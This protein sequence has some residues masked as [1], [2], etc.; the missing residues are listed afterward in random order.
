MEVFQMNTIDFIAVMAPLAMADQKQT[1]VLASITIAQSI[2]ESASGASA[3]GNNL[4]GIKGKGQELNTKEF[5]NG[6]WVTIKD[7]FRVY[8]TWSDSVSD[9][10]RF[11]VENTRY[12]RS[13]FFERCIDLDYKGAAQA[14]QNAG[15]ATDPQYAA[16]LITLI[17]QFKLHLYDL[18]ANADMEDMIKRIEMLENKV[19][20]LFKKVSVLEPTPPPQW[21]VDEFG[22]ASLAGFIHDPNGDVDFWRNTAVTLRLLKL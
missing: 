16:K 6:E 3:P 22:L 4:F 13:G 9:H 8:H 17:E 14:L 12:T 11:L 15:Y 18:E 20:Q 7:G 19:A 5:I 1:T 10:S 21:F 2:L